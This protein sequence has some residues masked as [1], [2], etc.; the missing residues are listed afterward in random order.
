MVAGQAC[1]RR[2]KKRDGEASALEIGVHQPD[3]RVAGRFELFCQGP[4]G[5]KV[6]AADA[7]VDQQDAGRR[8]GYLLDVD[9]TTWRPCLAPSRSGFSSSALVNSALALSYCLEF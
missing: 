8:G 7:R 1:V 9:A 4:R 5:R 6:P 3:A 2:W